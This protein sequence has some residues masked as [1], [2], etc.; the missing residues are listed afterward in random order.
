LTV[1]RDKFE[2]FLG[3]AAEDLIQYRIDYGVTTEEEEEA[4]LPYQVIYGWQDDPP[5]DDPLKEGMWH[6][7]KVEARMNG[8]CDNFCGVDG[9]SDP[10]WPWVETDSDS[11][12]RCYTLQNRNGMVKFRV[13]RFDQSP[14]T[15]SLFFPNGTPLWKFRQSYPRSGDIST[16]LNNMPSDCSV[17]TIKTFPDS[18]PNPDDNTETTLYYGAFMLSE[19]LNDETDP[20]CKTAC[21]GNNTCEALCPLLDNRTCWDDVHVLLANGVSSETCAKYYWQGA[22]NEGMAFKFVDCVNF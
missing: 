6:V 7:V 16:A 21:L 2:Y 14:E 13:T 12:E 22:A 4:G 20:A 19:R 11:F 17:A 3:G 10:G 5:K 15:S 1:A 18:T 9:T 8:K